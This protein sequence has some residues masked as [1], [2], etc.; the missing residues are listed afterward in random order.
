MART[1]GQRFCWKC[2]TALVVRSE[3]WAYS[4]F[5]G[6]P[7]YKADCPNWRPFTIWERFIGDDPRHE[8]GAMV[9]SDE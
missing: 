3:P 6:A 9:W 8:Y 1:F 7:L 4:T 2:G 5:D